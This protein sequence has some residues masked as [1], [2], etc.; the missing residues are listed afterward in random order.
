MPL[1][2]TSKGLPNTCSNCATL[3]ENTWS[4]ENEDQAR[5]GQGICANCAKPKPTR[6]RRR[7]SKVT[8]SARTKAT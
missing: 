8:D 2:V 5:A 1:I 7:Q 4:A 6:R 3:C